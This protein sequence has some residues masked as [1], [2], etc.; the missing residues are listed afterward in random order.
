MTIVM[1]ISSSSFATKILSQSDSAIVLKLVGLEKLHT[2][3]KESMERPM[4][5]PCKNSS[6]CFNHDVNVVYGGE[7]ISLRPTL[8]PL[9][10]I[11]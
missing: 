5:N 4:S 3:M 8:K 11:S 2:A 6:K 9:V 1:L 7:D 10:T